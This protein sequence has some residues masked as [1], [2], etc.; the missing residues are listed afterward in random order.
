M[1]Y[2]RSCYTWPCQFGASAAPGGKIRWYRAEPGAKPFP[3][4]HA[5]GSHVW[6][7]YNG[8]F[9]GAGEA[10]EAVLTHASSAGPP[11]PGTEFHGDPSWYATGVPDAIVFGP[12]PPPP[13]CKVPTVVQVTNVCNCTS[14]VENQ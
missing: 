12:N 4:P 8:P 10:N 1:D 3:T 13:K 14:V 7:S 6:E 5:F 9:N 2:L 11:F